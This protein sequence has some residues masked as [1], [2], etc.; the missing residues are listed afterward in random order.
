MALQHFWKSIPSVFL[1][2][3]SHHRLHFLH[4]MSKKAALPQRLEFL[5]LTAAVFCLSGNPA[6]ILF[7]L[8]LGNIPAY[9][10]GILRCI[11]V[12]IHPKL[13][14]IFLTK[15]TGKMVVLSCVDHLFP[16]STIINSTDQQASKTGF[17]GNTAIF[18]CFHYCN[19]RKFPIVHYLSPYFCP[20]C[21]SSIQI[22]HCNSD[23]PG[24]GIFTKKIDDPVHSVFSDHFFVWH[25]TVIPS[26]TDHH[27]PGCCI[28]KPALVQNSFWLAG[29]QIMPVAIAPDLYPGVVVITVGPSRHIHW[30]CR[31]SGTS[32]YI[33]HK[34]GFLTTAAYTASVNFQCGAGTH[35]RSLVHHFSRT[36]VIDLQCS[37]HHGLPLDLILYFFPEIG[38]AWFDLFIICPM[39]KHVIQKIKLWIILYIRGIFPE[40]DSLLHIVQISVK[41]IVSHIAVGHIAVQ[42]FHS[43]HNI[44][45]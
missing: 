19:R 18:V 41:G 20:S 36:P 14:L 26:G 31:D 39:K 3:N 15:S 34:D 22:F 24:F 10:A 44:R 23:P 42:I 27:G 45:T 38:T 4:G 16:V 43:D 35:V 7:F 9:S 2:Q 37:F 40:I 1:R 13:I 8:F 25:S 29:S 32:H 33:Y 17:K 11:H 28:G 30:S 5:N 6:I 12:K 21:R